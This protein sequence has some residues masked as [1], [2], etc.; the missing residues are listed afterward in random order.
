M[1][2]I[3]LTVLVSMMASA[4]CLAG[5]QVRGKMTGEECTSYVLFEKCDK[6][7]IDAV[8]GDDGKLY[9][10]TNYFSNVSSYKDSSSGDG[11]CWIRVK[12]A[13]YGAISWGIN[14]AKP[15]FYEKQPDGTYE[16]VDIETIVFKCIKN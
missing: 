7:N 15:K 11:L 3:A 8:K 14:L 9:N 16:H 4:T 12:S 5:Y 1:K 13:R 6:K 2:I 10:I